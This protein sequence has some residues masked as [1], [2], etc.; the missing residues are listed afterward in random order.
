MATIV[1]AGA[2]PDAKAAAAELARLGPSRLHHAG[3]TIGFAI[4]ERGPR[5]LMTLEARGGT[6][7][8]EADEI[9]RFGASTILLAPIAAEIDVHAVRAARGTPVKVAALQGWLRSLSPGHGVAPASLVSI[10][11]DLA[12]ELAAFDLLVAS[13]D[14]LLAD[15]ASPA[16]QLVA[17]RRR[18]GPGPT[19]I[20]TDGSRGAHVDRPGA[21]LVSTP[22]QPVAAESTVGAGDAFAGLVAMQ[23]GRGVDPVRAATE[24][25]GR[26]A[27]LLAGSG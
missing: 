11:P 27:D 23:L 2:E 14:D 19:L 25:A 16:A 22:A 6:L 12:S 13:A 20:V 24:A 7:T 10:A 18:F 17:L 5:R 26:V 9:D 21:E 8:L 4:D 15:G 1:L 3:V